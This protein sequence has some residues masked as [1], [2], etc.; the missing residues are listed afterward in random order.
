VMLFGAAFQVA[1]AEAF[2]SLSVCLSLHF[3]ALS[4]RC[5]GKITKFSLWAATD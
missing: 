1:I 4:K 3:A 2:I 5:K